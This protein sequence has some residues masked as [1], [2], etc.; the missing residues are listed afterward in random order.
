MEELGDDDF[1]TFGFYY[2][3]NS[4]VSNTGEN[5]TITFL[6]TSTSVGSVVQKGTLRV[7]ATVSNPP[8]NLQI[9]SITLSNRKFLQTANYLFEISTSSSTLSID[10]NGNSILGLKI[11]F[12]IEYK[13]IWERID[14]NITLTLTLGSTDFVSTPTMTNGTITSKFTISSPVSFNSA[15]IDFLFRN[16]SQPIDC[17]IV[18]VFVISL[19]DFTMNTIVAETLSNNIECPEFNSRLYNINVTG[20][21]QME[22]NSVN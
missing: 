9:N 21:L 3:K 4:N 10:I 2:L 22:Q 6:D 16:P 18:P 19:F 12:P 14:P 5:M 1:L 15:S 8:A 7:P 20:Y 17:S 11:T 13:Q